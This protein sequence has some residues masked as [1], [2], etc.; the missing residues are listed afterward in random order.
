MKHLI[1]ASLLALT[2]CA[3]PEPALILPPA[4]LATCADMPAAPQLPERDGTNAIERARDLATLDYI[5]ALRSAYGDCKSKTVGLKAW[6]EEA[7]R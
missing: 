6:M 5:L 7:G 1:S 3:T 2:A 4:S